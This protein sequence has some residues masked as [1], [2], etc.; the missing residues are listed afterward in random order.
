MDKMEYLSR[1]RN[2]LSSLPREERNEA[3]RYYNEMFLDAG[4]ENEQSVIASLG[5]PSELAHTILNDKKNISY[6]FT[7]TKKN[8]KKANKKM[9]KQQRTVTIVALVLT[10]P[11]WASLLLG[12]AAVIAA[13]FIFVALFAA[14]LIISGVVLIAMGVAYII[15]VPS[16]STTL[17]GIGISLGSIA[18]LLWT[19]LMNLSFFIL[20]IT[21]KG[22]MTLMN[23]L[24]GKTEVRAK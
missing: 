8:V 16:I 3:V 1:L 17:F 12:I 14:G 24:L 9:S 18:F 5:S 23:K 10:S 19:P 11:I 13:L 2:C 21:V 22:C 4:L 15:K 7:Q 20:K 6:A